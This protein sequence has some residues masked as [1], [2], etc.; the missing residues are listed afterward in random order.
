MDGFFS[1]AAE[2]LGA[3]KVTALDHYV[4]STDMAEYIKEWEESKRTGA[5]LPSPHESRYWRPDELPGRR[6]FDAAHAILGRRVEPVV[7]DF[8]TMDLATLGQFDVVLFLG[9]L[10]HMEDPLRAL[11]HVVEM[12]AHG[13]SVVIET[14]AEEIPRFNTPR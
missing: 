8:M 11:R 10:Y 13:G 9:V 6:P 1:F 14:A 4:W 12:T 7:G 5:L 2:R 3:A